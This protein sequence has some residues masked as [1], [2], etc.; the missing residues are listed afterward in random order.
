[1]MARWYD[2][3]RGGGCW[4][5]RQWL[6]RRDGR[7]DQIRMT[8]ACRYTHSDVYLPC[9]AALPSLPIPLSVLR[10]PIS[11]ICAIPTHSMP[12]M[13]SMR[14]CTCIRWDGCSHALP[15]PP[16]L[17]SLSSSSQPSRRCRCICRCMCRCMCRCRCRCRCMC[18]CMSMQVTANT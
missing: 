18:R 13:H 9:I 4:Y 2:A 3:V 15:Y 16:P 5:G 11:L 12:D 1:M 7:Y 8:L 17:A 10:L 14:T 6:L